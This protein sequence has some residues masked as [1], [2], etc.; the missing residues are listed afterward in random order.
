M[1]DCLGFSFFF[2]NFI[3]EVLTRASSVC[4]SLP[5]LQTFVDI[6]SKQILRIFF[7]VVWSGFS[8]VL[9]I[10]IAGKCVLKYVAYM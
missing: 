8:C 9:K 10:A 4:T 1:K 2:F 5:T 6:S 3:T 7:A